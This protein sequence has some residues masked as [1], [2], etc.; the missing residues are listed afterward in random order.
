M[1]EVPS[2]GGALR[3]D[4]PWYVERAADHQLFHGLANGISCYVLTSHQMGKS[5]LAVRTF[6]RLR[7]TGTSVIAIDLAAFGREISAEQWFNAVVLRAGRQLDLEDAV[8]RFWNARRGDP[9]VTRFCATMHSVL[10]PRAGGRLVILTDEVDIVRSLRDA[11]LLDAIRGRCEG[12]GWRLGSQGV[13]L[14]LFA[15]SSPAELLAGAAQD[16][17]PGL[18]VIPLHDFTCE[19]LLAIAPQLLERCFKNQAAQLSD[20]PG[21]ILG[22]LEDLLGR[23]HDWTGGHPYLSQELCQAVVGRLASM[24]AGQWPMSANLRSQLVDQ[25]CQERFLTRQAAS[26]DH[27]LLYV[28]RNLL[29]GEEERWDRLNLY[30]R[31][32]QGEAIAIERHPAGAMDLLRTG[33]ARAQGGLIQVR[34]RIYTRVFDSRWLDKVLEARNRRTAANG[35]SQYLQH[36][37]PC[38]EPGLALAEPPRNAA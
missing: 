38:I 7:S 2:C 35:L 31:V 17:L 9:P 16:C 8:E 6:Y 12:L 23:V 27:N 20:C 18:R 25:C 37:R 36:F 1:N 13:A 29:H 11:G 10:L 19:E 32:W 26:S 3:W 28:Q 21:T 5:S 33:V 4:C 14:G 30:Q 34:N 15:T 22:S 24:P